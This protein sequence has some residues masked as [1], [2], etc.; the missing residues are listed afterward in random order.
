MRERERE[1]V[2]VRERKKKSS[3]QKLSSTYIDPSRGRRWRLC[4]KLFIKEV[5]W[6]T[7]GKGLFLGTI[8]FWKVKEPFHKIVIYLP[9]T[10]KKITV[11]ESHIS[12]V[13]SEI[14][15]IGQRHNFLI[16]WII[17]SRFSTLSWHYLW[18]L[19]YT[20]FFYGAK[21]LETRA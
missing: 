3:L 2:M 5:S 4:I 14:F 18:V 9:W 8:F 11:K 16:Y 10:Y 20:Y 6:G 15:S 12:S 7:W 17:S 19:L 21:P 1:S 13:T